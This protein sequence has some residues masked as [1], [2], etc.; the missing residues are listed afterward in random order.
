M[1]T[2]HLTTEEQKWFETLPAALKEGWTVEPETIDAYETAEELQ[3]R[4]NITRMPK[5]PPVDK[6]LQKL[7][8][9]ADIK[10]VNLDDLPE[11]MMPSFFF[12]IGAKGVSIFMGA[13]FKLAKDDEDVQALCAMSLIR[14]DILETNASIRYV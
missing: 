8:D 14:H 7:R 3:V 9:G 11:E 5:F 13:L 12:A 2:L 6:L 4:L 1:N 10:D